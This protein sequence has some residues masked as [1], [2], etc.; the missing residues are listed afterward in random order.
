M[1]NGRGSPKKRS[2][3][4][5]GPWQPFPL[6]FLRS[7]SCASLSTHGAKLLLDCLAA[8]G[9]NGSGNGDFCLSPSVMKKR[10]WTSRST[11]HAAV[12]ELVAAKLLVQTRQ[13]SR[14]DCSLWA[15][16]LY[17]LDCNLN[18]LDVKPGS[19]SKDGWRL[20]TDKADIPPTD[21]I[22][23]TWKQVRKLKTVAPPRDDTAKKRPATG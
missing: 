6:D 21:D 17:P 7:R 12:Q 20:A 11:L 14:L 5:T 8:L 9:T 3:A 18:K 15:L 2:V 16:A 19:Y 22:P 4:V 13:G 10:G 1:A 23:A